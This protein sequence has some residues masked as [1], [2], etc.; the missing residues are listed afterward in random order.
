MKKALPCS[1]C[2][3]ATSNTCVYQ[4][5]VINMSKGK[6]KQKKAH[7][8]K[9]NTTP[10]ITT[11]FFNSQESAKGITSPEYTMSSRSTRS[12]NRKHSGKEALNSAS[13]TE[14]STDGSEQE[15][16]PDT[17]SAVL[18]Y[19]EEINPEEYSKLDLEQKMD[20]LVA[21]FNQLCA[22]VIEIDIALNYD[23]DGINT[24]MLTH[25]LQSDQ[26]IIQID[27]I[28][29]AVSGVQKEL[30][31]ANTGLEMLQMEQ[32]T[33]RGILQRH[34]NQLKSLNDKV[35][36]LTARSMENNITISNL[37]KD[38]GKEENCKQNVLEFLRAQVEIDADEN[39]IYVAHRIGKWSKK[40]EHP[41]MMVVRLKHPL[42][43][44]IFSN[45][46]NLKGKKNES[47]RPFYVNKQ[48]PD[49]IVARNKLIKRQVQE[50][51]S[52]EYHLPTNQKSKIEVR[53]KIVYTDG[54]P[55][56]EQL[57]VPN[58]EETFPDNVEK[59][60]QAKMKLATAE[61]ITEENS[62]FFAYAVRAGQ[63][64]EVRRAYKKIK[65]LHPGADHI[66]AAYSIRGGQKG[67]QDDGEHNAGFK[68]LQELDPDAKDDN[69]INP[70]EAEDAEEG[71]AQ[72]KTVNQ[73]RKAATGPA[74]NVAAF[75]VRIYGGIQL[76]SNRFK[77]IK[78]VA[79]DALEK[80]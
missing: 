13:D 55:V 40:Q 74:P 36:M 64:H 59:E 8:S 42:K 18:P 25:Q 65:R 76:G 62:T 47:G 19:P 57:P 28:K 41:R 78:Q 37:E 52:K 4:R 11:C 67:Y 26:N 49:Q 39:E 6:K 3:C 24:R 43:E 63:I 60:K 31:I 30:K 79:R 71:G 35:A 70:D 16:E 27:T 48:L 61:P 21:V 32:K 9:K 80:L 23:S 56:P 2:D 73:R 1:S 12:S 69:P 17:H 54:N 22:K 33:Y 5:G 58:I 34:D 10:K 20:K 51:K 75:V 14:T 50:I 77:Y 38:S 29:K 44:R 15:S 46:K 68:L 53:K 72:F 45:I 66:I 7:T